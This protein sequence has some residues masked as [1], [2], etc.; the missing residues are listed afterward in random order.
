MHLQALTLSSLCRDGGGGVVRLRQKKAGAKI[1]TFSFLL[2][3]WVLKSVRGA[4]EQGITGLLCPVPGELSSVHLL[5]HPSEMVAQSLS[6]LWH[7]CILKD[8]CAR[9]SF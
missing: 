9:L 3:G 4:V 8:L 1:E 5:S 2:D 6:L 7:P